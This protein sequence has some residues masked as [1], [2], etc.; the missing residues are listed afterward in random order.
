MFRVVLMLFAALGLATRAATG[1][2]LASSDDSSNQFFETRIRPVLVERC[3]SCHSADAKKLKGGL[4]LDSREGVLKGGDNGEAIVPGAPEKSR[5]IEAI[6][7]KNV[8]LQMPPKGMLGEQQIA[9]LSAWVKMGAP[10]PK[11]KAVGGAGGAKGGFD[12]AQR[13]AS[14]WAWQPIKAGGLAAGENR[15]RAGRPRPQFPF[16]GACGRG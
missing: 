5:L 3:F 16:A 4:Y 14:H 7:Y 6:G 1:E 9:D 12:L 2:T 11:G 10:W 15:Y 13:K 8:D